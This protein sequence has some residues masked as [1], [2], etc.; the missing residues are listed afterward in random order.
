MTQTRFNFMASSGTTF[1]D[2]L[3]LT[4][5]TRTY[6]MTRNRSKKRGREEKMASTRAHPGP[7]VDVLGRRRWT[8]ETSHYF[9]HNIRNG[10]N[11]THH[12]GRCAIGSVSRRGRHCGRCPVRPANGATRVA[13]RTTFTG[14]RWRSGPPSSHRREVRR[15]L[16]RPSLSGNF[17]TPTTIATT[18]RGVAAPASNGIAW[19]RHSSAAADPSG[20]NRTE[21]SNKKNIEI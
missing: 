6:E 10:K 2:Q 8:W 14:R 7:S 16:A 19:H 18:S 15:V 11:D 1:S 21:L 20:A 4:N 9:R 3:Q 13:T 17:T 5:N 12:R